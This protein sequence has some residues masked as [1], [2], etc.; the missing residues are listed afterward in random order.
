MAR[1]FCGSYAYLA[2][3]MV[4]KKGH[5]FALDWYLFGVLMYEM[6]EGLPPFYDNKKE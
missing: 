2:P 4:E 1:S 6:L 5:T 3:E